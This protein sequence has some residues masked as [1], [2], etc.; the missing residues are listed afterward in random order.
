MTT[1]NGFAKL[2][3]RAMIVL[4]VM[5]CFGSFIG[6]PDT[7]CNPFVVPPASGGCTWYNFYEFADG[8]TTGGSSFQNY[9]VAAGDPPR[10]ITLPGNAS[11]RKL[12]SGR[13]GDT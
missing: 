6:W 5:P 12:D 1:L 9:Y 2:L 3:M 11:F 8:S 13:Q 10:T 7:N 4:A